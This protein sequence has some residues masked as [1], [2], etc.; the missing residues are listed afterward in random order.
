MA[1][2]SMVPEW[3]VTPGKKTQKAPDITSWISSMEQLKINWEEVNLQEAYNLIWPWIEPV[4]EE[5]IT[6]KHRWR[7]FHQAVRRP[8]IDKSRIY[9]AK[10]R[11]K[12]CTKS[13]WMYTDTSTPRIV[14]RSYHIRRLQPQRRLRKHLHPLPE[15]NARINSHPKDE[16]A[17]L[18][19][20]GGI[21]GLFTKKER[22]ALGDD[23]P[24]PAHIWWLAG[25]KPGYKPPSRN[26]L[27]EW[28]KRSRGDWDEGKKRGFFQEIIYVLSDG[29]IGRDQWRPRKKKAAEPERNN[30]S[31]YDSD[32]SG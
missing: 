23:D 7:P 9:V 11:V 3:R 27:K 10:Q 18:R 25:G 5:Y 4:L 28:K 20:R 19:L 1:A 26:Q 14:R 24:I 29:R 6:G 30:R 31:S 15:A 22:Q 32:S 16:E 13:R 2:A 8:K 12:V 21:L 17:A